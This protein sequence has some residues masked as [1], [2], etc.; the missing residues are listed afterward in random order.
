[1]KKKRMEGCNTVE[2]VLH[3]CNQWGYMCYWRNCEEN[4]IL[5][6][7]VVAHLVSILMMGTKPFVLIMDTTYNISLL[8]AVGM[9]STRK[10]FTVAT[11]FM[12]NEKAETYEWRTFAV[13]G[14]DCNKTR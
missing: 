11:V 8:E 14:M 7:I 1:M 2:E 9:T 5:S 10:T 4:N 12:R 3:Q 6:D 13:E